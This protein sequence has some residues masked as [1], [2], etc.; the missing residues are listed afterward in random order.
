MHKWLEEKGGKKVELRVPS[1]GRGKELVDMVADN[2]REILQQSRIE[3]MADPGALTAALEGLQKALMLPAIPQRI[4]CYDISN[5]QGTSAVGSMVVFEGG[6]P[7]KSRYR[8]FQIRT[9]AGADDYAMMQEVLRRRFK[10]A[11]SGDRGEDTWAAFPD[12]VLIDGGRGQ[13]NAARQTMEEA[14]VGS[15]PT[16]SIAKEEEAIFLPQLA[17][18]LM[19]PR[20]SPALRLLQ[21]ARDEAHRFAVGYYRKVHKKRTFVS[22]LDGIPGVGAKRKRALLKRFGSVA[23]IRQATLDELGSV[24]GM[25]DSVAKRV[26]ESL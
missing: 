18:P 5:I 21:R 17:E 26:K 2:A 10:R 9:V 20:E 14:G 25:N 16:A 11:S 6:L 8:R 4:E 3:S 24:E 1:R 15:I 19:L 22:S 13:L 7:S 23:A 12:L